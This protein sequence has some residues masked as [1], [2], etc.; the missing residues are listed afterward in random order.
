MDPSSF[1][2]LLQLP[3]REAGAKWRGDGVDSD[4]AEDPDDDGLDENDE[5]GDIDAGIELNPPPPPLTADR[6]EGDPSLG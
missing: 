3:T 5:E 1:L 2:L 6:E 4:A